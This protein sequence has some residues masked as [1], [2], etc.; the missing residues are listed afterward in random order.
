MVATDNVCV[1]VATCMVLE[2]AI[3]RAGP[4]TE[5]P[6][7]KNSNGCESCYGAETTKHPCC[8]TCESV[9]EAYRVK[10]WAFVAASTIAQVGLRLAPKRWHCLCWF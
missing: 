6:V 10:G 7:P 5:K 8:P 2:L 1:C 4:E 3:T 9:R